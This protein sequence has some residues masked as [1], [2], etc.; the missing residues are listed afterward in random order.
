MFLH[1]TDAM[2]GDMGMVS[3][4]D[5]VVFL[6][7]SGSSEELLSLL[8]HV[9]AKGAR[10]VCVTS[11]PSSHMA[12]Q[13]GLHIHLP[14]LREL[15]PFDLAPVTS[16]TLQMIF[17]NTCAAVVMKLK[18]VSLMDVAQNHPADALGGRITLTAEAVMHHRSELAICSPKDSL[19]TVLFEL[20]RRGF[21]CVLITDMQS[22]LLGILTDGDLRRALNKYGRDAMNRP[23]SS[24]VSSQLGTSIFYNTIEP[25]SS[26]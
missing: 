25:Y 13:C 19:S 11:N 6:S 26:S 24:L 8:P 3:E 16:T 14:L 4:L 18:S 1:P 23:L 9:K 2:Y 17:G 22:C 10:L 20:S 5:I 21:G 7:K 15:C 12:L